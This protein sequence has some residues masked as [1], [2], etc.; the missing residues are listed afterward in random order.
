MLKRRVAYENTIFALSYIAQPVA[1]VLAG[2]L[3]PTD[4]TK[5]S[6]GSRLSALAKFFDASCP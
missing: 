5:R 3:C 2:G 1:L 4:G 6:L